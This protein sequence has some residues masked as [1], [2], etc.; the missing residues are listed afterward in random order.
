VA[1]AL[2]EQRLSV[3]IVNTVTIEQ[4]ARSPDADAGQAMQRVSS[5]SV[6]D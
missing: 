6:Q 3:N 2:E 5:V 1:E 4:I